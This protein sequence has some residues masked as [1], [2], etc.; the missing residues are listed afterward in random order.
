MTN[1]CYPGI[2]NFKSLTATEL[3][4]VYY[5]RGNSAI[6]ERMHCSPN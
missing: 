5:H 2:G 6:A 4:A 3:V 1:F